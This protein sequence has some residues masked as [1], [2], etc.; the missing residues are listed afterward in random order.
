[1]SDHLP[2]SLGMF[3]IAMAGRFAPDGKSR[4]LHSVDAKKT[5][6]HSLFF[7]QHSK[8]LPQ[9]TIIVPML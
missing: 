4:F 3:T 7:I 9:K 8:L 2:R 5:W 6:H 1:M